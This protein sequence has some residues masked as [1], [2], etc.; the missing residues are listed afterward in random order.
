MELNACAGLRIGIEFE[1]YATPID[2]T[3]INTT[4]TTKDASRR[5]FRTMS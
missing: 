5:S 2:T 1:C 4:N 3:N